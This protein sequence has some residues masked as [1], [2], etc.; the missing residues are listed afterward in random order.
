ME[1]YM[2]NKGL[3]MIGI[4]L[5]LT[6]ASMTFIRLFGMN[7]VNEEDRLTVVT[8]FYPIYIAASNVVADIDGVELVNLAD[9]QTGCLHDYQLTTQDMKILETADVFIINGGGIESF[10]E[11]VTENYPGLTIIDTSE[12]VELIPNESEHDHDHDHEESEHNHDHGENNPHIWL[13]PS[14]Y[15]KQVE[16]IRDGLIGY[17]E[18]NSIIYKSNAA[19]Y[20]TQVEAIREE[21]YNNLSHPINT[22]VVI[23]HDAFAYLADILGLETVYV[24]NL[25]DDTTLSAGEIGEI[26]DEVRYHQ[27][28]AL[29]TEEQYSL[30]IPASIG[31]ETGAEVYVIDTLVDGDGARDSY[32]RGMRDNIQVLK[33]S[34]YKD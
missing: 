26:I 30:Q 9:D 7:T 21:L 33:Q 25:E 17:N 19:Q 6:I 1:L 16:N 2:K 23:F 22:D 20:I 13:D 11:S 4:M 5:V 24:V 18:E 8:S 14:R 3:I 15:I 32:L 12:G 27:V 28:Q 31:K 29:Y 34:L 10:I